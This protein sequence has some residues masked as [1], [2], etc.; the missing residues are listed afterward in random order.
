MITHSGHIRLPEQMFQFIIH[1]MK[2]GNKMACANHTT[3]LHFSTKSYLP[4]VL[5]KYFILFNLGKPICN[6]IVLA[7]FYLWVFSCHPQYLKLLSFILQPKM[8]LFLFSI[9]FTNNFTFSITVSLVNP[10]QFCLT[11]LTELSSQ[12]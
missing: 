1:I 6:P 12:H 7:Y 3:F 2:R 10:F 9:N 8:C 11:Q 5:T 4:G